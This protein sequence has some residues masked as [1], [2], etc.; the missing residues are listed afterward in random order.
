[1]RGRTLCAPQ[2]ARPQ[3]CVVLYFYFLPWLVAGGHGGGGEFLPEKQTPS[4]EASPTKT[5]EAQ[6]RNGL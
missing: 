6:A 3:T 2:S 1:M 5:D 4:P